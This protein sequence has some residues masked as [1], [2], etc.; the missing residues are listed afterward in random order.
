MS[1]SKEKI[2]ILTTAIPRT[3][4]HNESI[5]SFY[6]NIT[7]NNEYQ[8][9]EFIHIINIDSPKKVLD[10]GINV[11]DT[12]NNL[13]KIIPNF[14]S[15]HFLDSGIGDFSKAFQNLILLA[16]EHVKEDDNYFILW[17]E[18]DWKITKCFS[19]LKL[20]N[21]FKKYQHF[22]F[23][24]RSE[25]I[26]NNPVIHSK[27]IHQYLCTYLEQKT[28]RKAN[29]KDMDP[30]IILH[31]FQ[32]FHLHKRVL[33]NKKAIFFYQPRVPIIEDLHQHEFVTKYN[34]LLKSLDIIKMETNVEDQLIGLDQLQEDKD[35]FYYFSN[36]GTK[37]SHNV[38][39]ESEYSLTYDLGR[40]WAS[41]NKIKKWDK[42]KA[43]VIT[44]I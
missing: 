11:E 8:N 26:C 27:K 24:F 30:D 25:N 43:D 37:Y 35:T 6:E 14:V 32:K 22:S 10:L 34:Q 4:I 42:L 41:Q 40:K 16:R 20:L 3:E 39:M 31:L 5:G 19:I 12:I 17:L 23:G 18:D 29:L 1:L 2:I 7:M 28:V 13:K 44:Y 15:S 33:T 9:F 38:F 36:Y 21:Q